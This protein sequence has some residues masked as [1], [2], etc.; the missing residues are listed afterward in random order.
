M[1][2]QQQISLP[3]SMDTTATH[4]SPDEQLFN[5]F[6]KSTDF[7]EILKLFQDLC[8]ELG[9]ESATQGCGFYALLRGKLR[10]WRTRALY[11]LLDARVA[12][13]EY[14]GQKSCIGKRVLIVGGG[15]VGLRAAI[16]AALLGASVDVVEKRTHFSRNNCLH[17]WP[18]VVSDLRNLGAKI[19][20]SKFASGGIDHIS[21]L[22]WLKQLVITTYFTNILC[23]YKDTAEHTAQNLSYAWGQGS[24]RG[25]V[26]WPH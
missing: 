23:R 18:F 5:Q 16:E 8:N 7:L 15:P 2:Q 6:H 25:D 14:E 24:P 26:H 21:K 12:L 10:A 11:P 13:P 17:L 19:F 9:L 4:S 22:R 3:S 20:Y 1:Y